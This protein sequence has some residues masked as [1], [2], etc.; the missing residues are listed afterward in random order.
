MKEIREE[1]NKLLFGKEFDIDS[2]KT[3]YKSMNFIQRPLGI[4]YSPS[5]VIKDIEA[6]PRILFP[7]IAMIFG[8]LLLNL[9]RYP[10]YLD[11]IRDTVIKSMET[12]SA[13]RGIQFT[14]EQI[15]KMTSYSAIVELIS[16]PIVTILSWLACTILLFGVVKLFKGKGKF[17]LYAS[18]TGYAYVVKLLLLVIT[19][20]FSFITD[21]IKLDMS[22]S[23]FSSSLIA[24]ETH[25]FIAGFFRAFLSNINIFSIW[26]VLVIAIGVAIVSKIPKKKVNTIIIVSFIMYVLIISTYGG[27]TESMTGGTVSM[28]PM[29]LGPR[30]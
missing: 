7:L 14:A 5:K 11:K 20:I 26:H 4:I 8:Q 9:A 29:M 3:E 15:D 28:I 22:F 17:K 19:F 2:S 25:T 18:I 30:R 13:A 27:I 23:V 12:A 1:N 21:S 6:K 24:D 10:L 16:T